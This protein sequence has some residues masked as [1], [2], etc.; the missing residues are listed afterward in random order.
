MG[1]QGWEAE[2][3][4]Q[5][6]TVRSRQISKVDSHFRQDRKDYYKLDY[7][8]T[9]AVQGINLWFHLADFLP[10]HKGTS[11]LQPTMQPIVLAATNISGWSYFT[12]CFR[13]WRK[14]G[15][16][17][18]SLIFKVK[19][20]KI[21]IPLKSKLP[22]FKQARNLNLGESLIVPNLPEKLPES[23]FSFSFGRTRKSS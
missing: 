18:R 1:S 11:Q 4:D 22:T 20:Q 21:S 19:W 5:N 10:G 6:V 9:K 8:I 23:S 17:S 16:I 14:T 3:L 7:P 12:Q 2:V 15:S 13:H